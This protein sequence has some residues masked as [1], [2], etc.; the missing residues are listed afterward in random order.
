MAVMSWIAIVLLWETIPSWPSRGDHRGFASPQCRLRVAG[1]E[2][3]APITIGDNCWIG[4]NPTINPGVVIGD[5]VVIGSG[6]VVTRNAPDNVVVTGVPARVIRYIDQND[7]KGVVDVGKE[8]DITTARPAVCE[9][10][11]LYLWTTSDRLI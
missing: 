8:E 9:G 4:A 1:D 7:K 5:N 6:A 2:L 10:Q 3:M 11:L